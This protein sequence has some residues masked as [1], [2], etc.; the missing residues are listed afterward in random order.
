MEAGHPICAKKS[1]LSITQAKKEIEQ[2]NPTSID[3][4]FRLISKELDKARK[5]LRGVAKLILL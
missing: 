3:I 1:K 2:Q 5:N 4:F